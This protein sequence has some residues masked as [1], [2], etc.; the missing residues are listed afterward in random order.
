MLLTHPHPDLPLEGEGGCVVGPRVQQMNDGWAN[1]QAAFDALFSSPSRQRR[2]VLISP[3]PVNARPY[4][5]IP[6]LLERDGVFGSWPHAALRLPPFPCRPRRYEY[7]N[8]PLHGRRH[9]GPQ[10]SGNDRDSVFVVG[11]RRLSA[12]SAKQEAVFLASRAGNLCRN[13][14]P[15]C[16]V[17]SAAMAYFSCCPDLTMRRVPARQQEQFLLDCCDREFF[18]RCRR[19]CRAGTHAG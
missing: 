1:K 6:L 17:Q 5:L 10:L 8:Q 16:P 7:A 3:S 11:T 14:S 9:R 18:S 13:P 2:A 12:A 19:H 4:S 15:R